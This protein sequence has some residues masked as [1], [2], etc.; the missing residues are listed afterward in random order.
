MKGKYPSKWECL[1]C[2][3]HDIIFLRLR[4]MSGTRSFNFHIQKE[5]VKKLIK[6][7]QTLVDNDNEKLKLKIIHNDE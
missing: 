6:D 1:N 7:L 5:D 3:D 4:G 2:D